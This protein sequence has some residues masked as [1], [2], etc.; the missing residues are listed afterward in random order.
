MPLKELIIMSKKYKKISKSDA[1][2]PSDIVITDEIRISAL[3]S[4]LNYWKMRY[5]LL[6]KYGNCK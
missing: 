3:K 5:I 4:E 6:E 1:T 2:E